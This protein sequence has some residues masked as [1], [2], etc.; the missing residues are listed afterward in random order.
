MD[1]D[2]DDQK[3]L[4]INAGG[5]NALMPAFSP[6]GPLFTPLPLDSSSILSPVVLDL[7]LN[8][9]LSYPWNKGEL[10]VCPDNIIADFDMSAIRRFGGYMRFLD[11]I[12][13]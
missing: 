2:F 6:E 13:I 9:F 12:L 7:H 3:I 4:V 5:A 8:L 11:L 10:I 1:R